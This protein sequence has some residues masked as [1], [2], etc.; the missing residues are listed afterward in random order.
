[1]AGGGGAP[2]LEALR[3]P[4]GS[5]RMPR[6][7]GPGA[8]PLIAEFPAPADPA[9]GEPMMLWA[10]E[11]ADIPTITVSASAILIAALDM[12]KLLVLHNAFEMRGPDV[13]WLAVVTIKLG[14]RRPRAAG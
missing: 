14:F 10:K 8:I 7:A 9:I 4:L 5:L 1:M 13:V 2:T 11:E 12:E 3:T 6:F